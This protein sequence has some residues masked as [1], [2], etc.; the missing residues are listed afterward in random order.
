MPKQFDPEQPDVKA[1]SRAN[2]RVLARLGVVV[3]AMFGF[4]FAMVPMYDV[5]CDLTGL[6]GKSSR[7]TVAQNV[8]SM[9]IDKNRTVTVEFVT[10]LN[11]S[12]NW[13]FQPMRSTMR[14]HPGK[15]Y[16]TSFYARNKALQD[17][18]GQAIPSI[19]PA[20]AATYLRKTECFC[21]RRQPFKAGQRRSMPVSFVVDAELPEEINTI[22]LSY[23]FF[24]VTAQASLQ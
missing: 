8:D 2:G 10:N 22:T 12:M 4:G 9:R 20:P 19:A 6:N 16:T 1:R 23:T 24:D 18:V 3:V 17:M 5:F 14:V 13:E 15:L 7:M 11:Q 21:F